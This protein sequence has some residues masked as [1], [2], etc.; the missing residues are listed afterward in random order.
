M[1][2]GG[3][4]RRPHR[5][6]RPRARRR[7][8]RRAG[9]GAR[10]RVPRRRRPS[11]LEAAAEGSPAPDRPRRRRRSRPPR[12]RCSTSAA[13]RSTP[14]RARS[15]ASSPRSR[16][17]P[18]VTTLMGKGAFPETH[19][20][21]FGWPGHAR[22][23]VVE[24]GDQQVRPP[25]RRRRPL[26]RPRHG[27]ALRLRARRDGHPPRH[28]LG[29]DL[30]APPGGHPGGR[31]PEAGSRRPHGRAART[32][33]YRAC[34]AYRA[35]AAPA[36]R[37]AR[38]VP[39]PLPPGA[40]DSLKPQ[41]V[42]ETLQ[43]L[44]AGRDDVVWTT[45]VGQHQM[46]AMQ[47]LLCDRP[48][49]FITSGGLGTMGYGVPAAIGAKA[50]RPDATVVCVDGDGCFQ[51]TQP[52]ARDVGARGPAD[53][54]RDRQ[55]RLPRDGPA[56]AG[57]VLR[58][59]AVADPPH[60]APPRLREAR[61]GLRR[62]RLHGRQRGRARERA[63]GGA[64]VRSHRRRRRAGRRRRAV[65]PDDP[66]RRSRARPRRVPGRGQ[67]GRRRWPPRE[68]HALGP[69]RE[70]ARCADADL[71]HVRAARVQH[72]EPLGRADGAPRRLAD[73]APRRLRAAPA[74]AD[75][76]ADA[77][78]RERPPGL[79]ARAR[80]GR[81][82]RARPHARSRPR[83]RA[84]ASSSRSRRRSTH[85]SPTSA[86]TRSSSRSW[87]IPRRSTRSRSS[88]GRTASRS[89]SAPAASA[90]AGG[91]HERGKPPRQHVLT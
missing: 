84:A 31:P 71:E 75:R 2:E 33:R 81:R 37:L 70:Q 55:Q 19:E 52:G 74:R 59:A 48:R 34:S 79:G 4:P 3:V 77:Q 6:L 36:R 14:T 5:P 23:E 56:V 88:S 27:Q 28:R 60:E 50:A 76:E 8:A 21:H 45:G 16:G 20:L 1:H 9:G 65:L 47:Y 82:A 91:T 38:G 51:M 87:A 10:L 69:R 18:V 39:A 67:R 80:R 25:G 68:T 66:G 11:R 53:R 12:G 61:G 49:S 86:P 64:R 72:R 42:L 13:A 40:G 7:P 15:C 58:R 73:H 89:S 24:L 44:T 26:R 83:P 90:S 63:R 78:A 46:W 41:L 32:P 29:R 85:A 17:F 43:E 22:A 30:Q 54:R 57:H 62:R 35:M